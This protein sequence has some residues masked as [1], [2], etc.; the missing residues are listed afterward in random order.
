MLTKVDEFLV[1]QTTDTFAAVLS[2]DK[3][4]NDG[5][6]ICLCDAGGNVQLVSTVRLYQNN[7]V[8]DGFVCIRHGSKQHN[9][10]VSRRLRPQIDHYGAGP[11]RIEL[12]EPMNAVRLVLEDSAFG[13]A[14]DVVC[15]SVGA[16][17][18]WPPHP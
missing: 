3:H 5:H 12:V 4:W 15:Y 18:R 16:P 8:L 7:D 14:C 10:R 2:E 6:Y 9:F 17:D 11:L 13:I 1:H